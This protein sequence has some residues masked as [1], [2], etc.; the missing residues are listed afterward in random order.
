[1][2]TAP[3]IPSTGSRPSSEPLSIAF[4]NT[5]HMVGGKLQD[6]V[7]TPA[8]LAG[9]LASQAGSLGIETPERELA[10]QVGPAEVRAFQRLR[11]AVR[12]LLGA[13]AP[14]V[15]GAAIDLLN[16]TSSAVPRWPVL[17]ISDEGWSVAERTVQGQVPV[18]LAAIA[19]DAIAVLGTDLRTQV[20]AC[21]AP[22]CILY[23]VK[24]R[25]R[26]E[27]CCQACGNRARVARHYRRHHH[28][29]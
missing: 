22:G 25:P 20:R 10:R 27:W 7:R 3:A 21:Q 11:E 1:M 9:W 28:A 26:R 19:R 5:V 12:A 6:E 4:A 14:H 2:T 16:E 15:E 17:A 24:D 18:A 23:F 29:G 13:D 8:R